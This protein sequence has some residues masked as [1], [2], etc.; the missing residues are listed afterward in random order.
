[1]SKIPFDANRVPQVA[2]ILRCLADLMETRLPEAGEV[3]RND[4]LKLDGYDAPIEPR[5]FE[6]T[7]TTTITWNGEVDLGAVAPSRFERALDLLRGLVDE[8]CS[9]DHE[10]FCQAHWGFWDENARCYHAKIREL[11]AEQDGASQ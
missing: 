2:S 8:E 10:G 4:R 6:T 7:I 11:L 5:E 9:L 3:I 1:M